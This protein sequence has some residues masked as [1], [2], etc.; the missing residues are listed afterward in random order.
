MHFVYIIH[1]ESRDRFYVGES[2]DPLKRVI[3]HNQGH[4]S[5]SFSRQASDWRLVFKLE[6]SGRKQAL[7]IEQ[8]IKKMKS[9][10]YI[11]NLLKYKEISAKL[12]EMYS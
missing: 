10:K 7:Q 9:R 1:S 3:Q 4:Y 6:C 8:H 2:I 12:K 11:Q 5:D